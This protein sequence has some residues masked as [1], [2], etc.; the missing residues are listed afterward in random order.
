MA[1]IGNGSKLMARGWWATK[2]GA[3][4]PNCVAAIPEPR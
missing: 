2:K 1:L 3:P 4:G